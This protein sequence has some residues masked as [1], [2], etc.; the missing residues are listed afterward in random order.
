[1]TSSY[2]VSSFN[3][4][5]HGLTARHT[6]LPWENAAEYQALLDALFAEHRPVSPTEHHLVVQLAALF[7]R[8]QRLLQAEAAA[9]R[10]SL[11]EQLSFTQAEQVSAGA[12]AHLH[13]DED[14]G[15]EKAV[16][17]TEQDA[18]LELAD[19]ADDEAH[20]QRALRILK[21]GGQLVCERALAALR[22]DTRDWW[23]QELQDA[24]EAEEDEEGQE[25]WQPTAASLR[26]FLETSVLPYLG[27]QRQAIDR[28]PLIRTQAY[29]MAI[30]RAD[31][32]KLGR[33]ETHLTRQM[34][35]M[36]AM[37]MRLKENRTTIQSNAA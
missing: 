23:Q 28:R 24:E 10:D 19:L 33:Y 3:A 15:A 31:L 4:T 8:Q 26:T 13:H 18:R 36:L 16:Q 29:G 7:W 32:E 35:R 30:V 21:R 6:V 22:E 1:M 25:A 27:R 5:Q 11:H 12:L 17:T 34:Q 14:Q 37:L 9:I 20:V 2:G